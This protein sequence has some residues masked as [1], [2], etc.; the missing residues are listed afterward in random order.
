[1]FQ[2]KLYDKIKINTRKEAVQ[3]AAQ[4]SKIV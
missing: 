4:G 2:G 3:N 1:M